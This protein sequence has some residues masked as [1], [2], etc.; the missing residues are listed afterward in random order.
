MIVVLNTIGVFQSKHFTQVICACMITLV[1]HNIHREYP[2]VAPCLPCRAPT[3]TTI[4]LNVLVY[5]C[6]RT[7]IIGA[8]ALGAK[9]ISLYLVTS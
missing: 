3:S 4:I 5:S 1:L 8:S 2:L 6:T 9:V 7:R